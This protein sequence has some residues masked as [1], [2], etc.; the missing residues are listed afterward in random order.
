MEEEKASSSSTRIPDFI[1]EMIR[2]PDDIAAVATAIVQEVNVMSLIDGMTAEQLE[3]SND[4]MT[5]YR[6]MPDYVLKKLIEND[7]N[8]TELEV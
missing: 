7:S 8:V 6:G 5:R 2:K 1:G 3:K 4:V